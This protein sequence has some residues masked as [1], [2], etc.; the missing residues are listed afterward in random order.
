[1]YE[2]KEVANGGQTEADRAKQEAVKLAGLRKAVR[3]D[4][5]RRVAKFKQNIATAVT[6]ESLAKADRLNSEAEEIEKLRD[7]MEKL[8]RDITSLN[9]MLGNQ[10]RVLQD[11]DN[12]A[13]QLEHSPNLVLLSNYSRDCH[14][15][16]ILA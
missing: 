9:P 2:L 4:V 8:T 11:A 3:T 1:M 5:Q 10:P 6:S 7:Q 12:E 14:E 13:I 16:R 15:M